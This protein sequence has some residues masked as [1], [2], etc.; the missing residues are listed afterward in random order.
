MGNAD[1]APIDHKDFESVWYLHKN[2]LHHRGT[3]DHNSERRTGKLT[4]LATTTNPGHRFLNIFS[5]LSKGLNPFLSLQP[6]NRLLAS[7]RGSYA[8][9]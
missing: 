2:R 1:L 5:A 9:R 4:I 8:D 7:N 3:A 6:Q